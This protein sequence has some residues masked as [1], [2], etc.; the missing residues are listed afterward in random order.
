MRL[1]RRLAWLICLTGW[2]LLLAMLASLWFKVE[3]GAA[4][5]EAMIRSYAEEYDVD[6]EFLVCIA[7]AESNFDAAALGRHGEVGLMQFKAGTWIWLREKMGLPTWTWLRLDPEE[8][9]R[10]AA[11][12]FG[13]MGLERWWTTEGGC[14]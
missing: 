4:D 1:L 13:V 11:Y 6:P 14:A 12:A 10:T 9:A 8:S 7:R 5:I 2:I 3:A